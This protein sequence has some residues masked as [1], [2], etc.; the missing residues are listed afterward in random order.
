M[1]VLVAVASRHHSTYEIGA[2]IA[3]SLVGA[4]LDVDLRRPEE[5][6]ALDGYDGVVL[7]SGI[8]AG[9]WL[10]SAVQLVERLGDE[11]R[12]RPVWLFSSGPIGDS[13][14]PSGDPPGAAEVVASLSPREHRVF[15]GRLAL[16]ELRLGERLIL[17]VGR[18]RASDD[19]DWNAIDVWAQEIAAAMAGERERAAAS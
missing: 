14:R 2:R 6:I 16:G 7:G 8:Y 10:P 19:R 13:A 9:Q 4:G 11:F 12:V 15:G 1:N 5:V 18:A 3:S 17:T